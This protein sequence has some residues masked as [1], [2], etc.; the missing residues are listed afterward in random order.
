M[1]DICQ[2]LARIEAATLNTFHHMFA[3]SISDLSQRS[4]LAKRVC[5]TTYNAD[6]RPAGQLWCMVL[7]RY[8]QVDMIKARH[9]Y[10]QDWPAQTAVS[11][12]FALSIAFL[13]LQLLFVCCH[14]T[15]CIV[16]ALLKLGVDTAA[17]LFSAQNK[18]DSAFD[19][20]RLITV[21]NSLSD[22]IVS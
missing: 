19:K 1:I 2:P 11:S 17:N 5:T 4:Q 3:P 9:N 12:Q 6:D 15:S 8:L 20:F 22:Y 13:L 14:D 18:I 16:Q 7:G 10:K 21:P